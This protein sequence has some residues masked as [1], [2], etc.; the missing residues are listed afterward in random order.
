MNCEYIRRKTRDSLRET[1]TI[2]TKVNQ[3]LEEISQINEKSLGE[4]VRKKRQVVN[5]NK[6]SL[7]V[8]NKIREGQHLSY[9]PLRGMR[10]L[11]TTMRSG[12]QELVPTKTR[13]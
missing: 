10:I 3:T 4:S 6:K 7:N 9:L 5:H 2:N 11:N 8:R 13:R 1:E 12:H